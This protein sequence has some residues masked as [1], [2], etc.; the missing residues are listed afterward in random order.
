MY[1]LHEITLAEL[2]YHYYSRGSTINFINHIKFLMTIIELS[3]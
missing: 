2:E 3:N 1:H